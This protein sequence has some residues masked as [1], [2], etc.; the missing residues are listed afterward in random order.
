MYSLSGRRCVLLFLF[1]FGGKFLLDKLLALLFGHFFWL[2]RCLIRCGLGRRVSSRFL[3]GRCILGSWLFFAFFTFLFRVF[4]CL[5]RLR[6]TLIFLIVRSSG[7]LLTFDCF[8]CFGV[9]FR[10][11]RLFLLGL[12]LSFLLLSVVLG[13]GLITCGIVTLFGL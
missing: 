2:R 5:L 13:C 6:G 11:F 7:L 8:S 3:G 9:A 4:L 12:L 1:L 10:R